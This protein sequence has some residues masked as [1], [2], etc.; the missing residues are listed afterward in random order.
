MVCREA[1]LNRK[2]LSV[3]WIDYSKAF[4]RVPHKWLRKVLKSIRAPKQLRRTL[5][6]LIPLWRS[7]FCLGRGKDAVKVEIGYQHAVSGRLPSPLLFCLSIAPLS[8][9][10]EGTRHG[11]A[12][13]ELAD[14]MT[15]TLFMDDLKVYSSDKRD[16]K[17]ALA[18][19]DRVS[20]AVEKELGL[21]KCAVAH[22]VKGKVEEGGDMS[23]SS[24]AR[25]LPA[26]E[27]NPYKCLGIEQVFKPELKTIRQRL[28]KT[29]VSRLRKIWTSPLNSKNKV[30]AT[31]TWAV[32]FFRY[33]LVC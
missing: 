20:K 21:R 25:I 17:Q 15:H 27:G 4:N 32:A 16:L 8:K 22:V 13:E 24:G 3:A 19:V 18:I 12:R 31:N 9:A 33:Y 28:K 14:S 11:F 10:L 26:G 29:Y 5:A 23:L 1:V 7:Q 30:H 6:N 2:D